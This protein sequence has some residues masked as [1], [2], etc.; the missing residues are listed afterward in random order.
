MADEEKLSKLEEDKEKQSNKEA[1]YIIEYDRENCIGAGACTAVSENW[2]M[3]DDGKADF[4]KKEITEKELDE[5]MEAAE[6][7]PVNVIHIIDKK[8]GKRLI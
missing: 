8:T 6:V 7:C 3:N 4:L 2:K 1:Q 5:Q